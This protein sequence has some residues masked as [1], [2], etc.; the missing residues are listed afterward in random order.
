M[1]PE[2]EMLLDEAMALDDVEDAVEI[3]GGG[4]DVEIGDSEDGE[5]VNEDEEKALGGRVDRYDVGVGGLNDHVG[6]PVASE[7]VYVGEPYG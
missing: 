3:D 6:Q 7:H 4:A 5:V 1:L 2:L